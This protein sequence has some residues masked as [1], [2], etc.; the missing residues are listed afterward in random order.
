[1]NSSSSYLSPLAVSSGPGPKITITE[2]TEENL[3]FTLYDCDLSIANSLR[4][5][6]LAEIPTMAID[7]VEVE[8]NTSV[9]ADEF[10][11]HR[12]GLIPLL[13][14]KVRDFK[15]SRDCNCMQFCPNCSVELTLH[16]K[17]TEDQTKDVTSRE[18]IS[19]HD[20]VKPIS[21]AQ[22]SPQGHLVSSNISPISILK[23]RKNQEIK[24]K[25]IAKKVKNDPHEFFIFILG[26]RQ[27]ACK[28]E[29]SSYC[30]F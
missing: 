8:T 12:L 11:A 20:D 30:S 6:L 26:S 10:I 19:N 2:L 24:M 18:L 4:R 15:Y 5:I 14:H 13:S 25:C 7:L 9:L 17:C 29:S 21:E 3:K 27:R 22:I 1:M 28:M 23:L 16:V